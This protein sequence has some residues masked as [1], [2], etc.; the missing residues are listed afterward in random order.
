VLALCATG[1]AQ[2]RLDDPGFERV[3]PDAGTAPMTPPKPDDPDDADALPTVR[4]TTPANGD[5]VPQG[6]LR[7]EGEASDDRGVASVMVKVGPNVA[8]PAHTDDNFK[9]FWLESEVPE[10]MFAVSAEARDNAAQLGDAARIV[11]IGPTTGADDGAPTVQVLAPPDGSAPLHALVLVNGTATDD[12]AV[13]SMDLLRNGELLKERSVETDDFFRTWSRLVP[14]IPG[15]DN[16]LT[17][18][19]RDAAGHEG[20]AIL[21][22]FGRAEIDREPPELQVTSPKNGD[23]VNGATLQVT[24]TATDEVGLREVKARIGRVLSGTT[25]L[26]YGE[27]VPAATQDG[28]ATFEVSLPIAE[29]ALTLEVR[30]LDLNGL[31]TSVTL[32]LEN[33]FV[34]EWSEEVQIPLRPST[35]TAPPA[36]RFELDRD[37]VNEVMSESIQRDTV[38]LELETTDMLTS[39]LNQIK[40]SCGTKWRL[41][42]TNPQH[43]CTVTDLGRSY[44]ASWRSSPEF[45]LVRLLTMTPKNAVVDGTSVANMKNLADDWNIG[46]GFQEILSDTLG[47]P[48]TQEI[49]STAGAVRAL[50]DFWMRSHPEV[51]SGAK[52][53]ITMYDAMN[54]LGPLKERFGPAYEGNT[55]VHPGLVDPS[56]TPHSK[57]F[58]DAFQLILE[59]RSNLRWRDGVELLPSGKSATKD[60]IALVADATGPTYDDVL[61]FDFTDPQK[62]DV[63]GL[64][65]APTADLR[66]RIVENPTFVRSCIAENSTCKNNT[67]SAPAA[68]Y[69]WA[70]PAYQM[71]TIVTGGAYYDYR[72]RSVRKTYLLGAASIEVGRNGNAAGWAE[73]FTLFNLG[74]PPPDQYLW[75]LILEIG[76]KALHKVDNTTIP[77]GQANAAFTLYDVDVG[78]T[79]AEIRAAIRPSLQQQR[80]KL[81]RR[82]LGDY[83]KNNGDVDFYLQRGADG[84]HY[85]FFAA[86]SDPRPN[87]TYT[88]EKPGFFA[89]EALTQKVSRID[90]AAAGD[91]THEK[92]ALSAGEQTVYAQS[93]EGELFRLRVVT[94][95]DDAMGN[96]APEVALFVARKVR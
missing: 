54:D 50:Q 60:Y 44:G 45:S 17:F 37:G 89:D 47:I 83:A 43:D 85:L 87:G 27:Y 96:P 77:E 33:A 55:L 74:A 4:I 34:P 23:V 59:A 90:L 32:L 48:V 72:T 21:T 92:L 30:A 14:L 12:R 10:G 52:L 94:P 2:L 66:M 49:V 19:A 84:R 86:A 6:V 15:V 8:L 41:N 91:A 57:V 70:N 51:R 63:E 25:T 71:E 42:N 65:P 46:G 1:C 75:E 64:T 39:A 38:L 93:E 79:A 88:Y 78:L 22:L 67:P 35:D 18:I 26:S 28:F 20:R 68:G 82:L 73:F 31:G 7:I 80:H 81:S 58:T 76:Q 56:F 3:E 5:A 16:E 29:G 69:V 36:L 95:E 9:H 40:E 62:F 13:V 11:L 53:P 24:G 61:E